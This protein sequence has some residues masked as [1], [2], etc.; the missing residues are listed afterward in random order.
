MPVRWQ[1]GEFVRPEP[2][3]VWQSDLSEVEHLPEGRPVG[4]KGA[5]ASNGG[6]SRGHPARVRPFRLEVPIPP[7]AGVLKAVALIGVFAQHAD[8]QFE[9]NGALGASFVLE[10]ADGRIVIR[11]ELV[12]GRH[13]QDARVTVAI[14]RPVGDG[15]QIETLGTWRSEGEEWRV[16]RLEFPVEPGLRPDHLVLRDLGT[17]ASFVLFEV[18]FAFEVAAVCP[19]RGQTGTLALAE[20]GGIVRLRDRGRYRQALQQVLHAMHL[21]GDDLDEARGLGLTF[22]AVAAAATLELGAP[23]TMHRFQLEAARALEACASADDA[24]HCVEEKGLKLLEVIAPHPGDPHD[25]LIDRAIS[26]IERNYGRE[27]S[28]DDIAR[29]LGLSTSHFRHLFRRKTQQ[30]FSKFLLGFRLE[31]AREMILQSDVPVHEVA[32]RTGFASPA[33]FSRTFHQRFGVSPSAL[34]AGR[35][36]SGLP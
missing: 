22:L 4:Q 6:A 23:R 25:S 26:L 9:P 18:I 13:Y 19:F 20:V 17:P 1:F 5:W 29:K 31:K 24:V 7:E 36:E 34:R 30:P 8:P 35:N 33:H 2:E 3:W 32:D 12:Q 10:T 14:K 16:D 27:I 21:A 11:R 28:D 15:A